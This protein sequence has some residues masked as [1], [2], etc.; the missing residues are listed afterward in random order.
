[1]RLLYD[2]FA[3][4]TGSRLRGIGRFT[5]SLAEAMAR[6]RGSHEMV[7]LANG[8][9]LYEASTDRLRRN[10]ADLPQPAPLMTYTYVER[11]ALACDGITHESLAT[12]L[13]NGAYAALTPDVILYSTPF[14]GWGEEGVGAV[15]EAGDAAPLRVAVLYDFI[16]WLFPEQYLDGVAGYRDWYALRLAALQRF[17]LLLAIS[18]ATRDDAIRILGMAPEQVVNISGAASAMFHAPPSQA[19]GAAQLPAAAQVPAA[20]TAPATPAAATPASATAAAASLARFGIHRPFVLY[21]GNVDFRKNQSGMLQAYAMLRPPLRAR[22]QLVLTQVL[23]REQ[24]FRDVQAYGMHAEDVVVTGHISDDEMIALYTCCALFVFPSLYEG[25]GLPILEAM[26]C[27]AAVIAGDNSSIPEVVGRADMLFDAS[28][29]AAIATA[30]QTVLD[31][32]GL[33]CD[34]QAYGIARART[35]TWERSAARAWSAIESAAATKLRR[36]AQ[37]ARSALIRRRIAMICAA[38]SV[39]CAAARHALQI[40]PLL[41]DEFDIDL[42]VQEGVWTDAPSIEARFPIYPHTR[43]A[44]QRERY[45]AL[46]YQFDNT[47]EHAFMLPMTERF[48]GIVVLHDWRI[49]RVVDTCALQGGMPELSARELLYCHGLQGLLAHLRHG[50]RFPLNRHLIEASRHL[51]LS[52]TAAADG[53]AA[54]DDARRGWRPPALQ[55]AADP[56]AALPAYRQ[57]IAASGADPT[58]QAARAMAPMLEQA[59]LPDAAL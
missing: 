30:M 10:L 52:E 29:P 23:D 47:P 34:L 50:S 4:Q 38:P 51:L 31:D 11:G 13:I 54:L 28:D 12:V 58:L 21:T 26:A 40:L 8:L 35:F 7:A 44:A 59:G 19:R 49:D 24:F 17:D 18:D 2:L 45:A 42:Y 20:A 3:C 56:A 39:D 22:H 14:E 33:R 48:P 25:F 16:P 9:P 32:D 27:G 55:L 5:L 15:P 46:I 41:A 53:W 36:R 43:M 57:A 1:M 37:L 6:L